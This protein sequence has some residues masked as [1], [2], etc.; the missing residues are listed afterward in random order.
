MGFNDITMEKQ[1]GWKGP[2]RAASAA[3]GMG[4]DTPVS[5]SRGAAM[6]GRVLH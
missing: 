2:Q 6:G 4:R 5:G 1:M 3:S